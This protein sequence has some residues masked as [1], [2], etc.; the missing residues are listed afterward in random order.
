LPASKQPKQKENPSDNTLGSTGSSMLVSLG[1]N[2]A[3][4]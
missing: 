2:N 1:A 4:V 3:T